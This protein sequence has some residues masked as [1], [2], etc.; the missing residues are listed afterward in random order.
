MQI[1]MGM[2]GNPAPEPTSMRVPWSGKRESADG[3]GQ[4][5]IHDGL[6][7]IEACQVYLLIPEFQL[8]QKDVELIGLV[9]READPPF[10]QQG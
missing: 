7:G 10:V 8:I 3:I 6:P 5:F 9:H 1:F 2:A 4:E